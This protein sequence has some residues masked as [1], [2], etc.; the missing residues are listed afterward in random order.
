MPIGSIFYLSCY[1]T[2]YGALVSMSQNMQFPYTVIRSG[3]IY[4]DLRQLQYIWRAGQWVPSH[5]WH[6]AIAIHR[7]AHFSIWGQENTR[8]Q[9]APTASTV[10][11]L[12]AVW[13]EQW[14][15]AAACIL[16]CTV[17]IICKC[18]LWSQAATKGKDASPTVATW[19]EDW[20][21][22]THKWL[23]KKTSLRLTSYVNIT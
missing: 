14:A 13:Q 7:A 9:A 18:I 15:T 16:K 12:R 8:G 3:F 2:G 4:G 10:K 23:Q 1:L 22:N 21:L 20:A 11:T 6:C 5:I 19:R 17:L